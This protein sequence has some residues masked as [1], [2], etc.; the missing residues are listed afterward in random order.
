MS[1]SIFLWVMKH[2][3][4]AR[5]GSP[6]RPGGPI[7]PTS[8]RN[9]ASP[10]APL[11]PVSPTSP[12]GPGSPGLPVQWKSRLQSHSSWSFHTQ[13]ETR[14]WHVKPCS[15]WP[16]WWCRTEELITDKSCCIDW[17]I[18]FASPHSFYSLLQLICLCELSIR[19]RC[20]QKVAV[21]SNFSSKL[22]TLCQHIWFHDCGD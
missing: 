16:C 22:F 18:Q 17:H 21:I 11:A 4:T 7:S 15:H 1:S 8:P 19:H 6:G 5:P 13:W 10:R 12:G 14:L 9:P 3:L 2:I 20:N